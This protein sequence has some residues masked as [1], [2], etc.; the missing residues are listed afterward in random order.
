M[1]VINHQQRDTVRQALIGL[2]GG[3]LLAFFAFGNAHAAERAGSAADAL[4]KM[5][6]AVTAIDANLPTEPA[7]EASLERLREV[8]ARESQTASAAVPSHKQRY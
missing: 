4:D 5:R 3:L 6:A 8:M 1:Q 2:G 7:L